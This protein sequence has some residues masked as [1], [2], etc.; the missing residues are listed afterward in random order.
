MCTFDPALSK[1]SIAPNLSEGEIQVYIEQELD[2][3]RDILDGETDCKWVYQALLEYTLLLAKRKGRIEDEDRR[4]I[5]EWLAELH[6]LDPARN[7]RWLDLETYVQNR[8]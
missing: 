4:N 7:G 5:L 3:V 1:K 8:T 2:Y 6:R